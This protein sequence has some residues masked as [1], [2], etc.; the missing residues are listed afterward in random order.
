M[1]QSR[2]HRTPFAGRRWRFRVHLQAACRVVKWRIT[3]GLLVTGSIV[4]DQF[5]ELCWEIGPHVVE[6][7]GPDD[8]ELTALVTIGGKM[9]PLAFQREPAPPLPQVAA[10]DARTFGAFE[11]ADPVCQVCGQTF[12]SHGTP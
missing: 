4:V 2:S 9:M 6:W 12:C 1:R 8:L 7:Q 3:T 10:D 5:P 11:K